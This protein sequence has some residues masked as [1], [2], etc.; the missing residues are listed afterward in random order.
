MRVHACLSVVGA[1]S[2]ASSAPSIPGTPPA[3]RAW[4]AVAKPEVFL[5]NVPREGY[6]LLPFELRRG[7]IGVEGQASMTAEVQS[8]DGTAWP[9]YLT[10]FEGEVP[11]NPGDGIGYPLWVSSRAFTP[12]ARYRLSTTIANPPGCLDADPVASSTVEFTVAE[13][14]LSE[15]RKGALGETTV[16]LDWMRSESSPQCC[17]ARSTEHCADPKSC[18]ACS[19]SSVRANVMLTRTPAPES[20]YLSL[21]VVARGPAGETLGSAW[22]SGAAPEYHVQVPLCLSEYCAEVAV[23]S[24]AMGDETVT[25]GPLCVPGSDPQIEPAADEALLVLD[26][27][28]VDGS[29][30]SRSAPPYCESYP[31]VRWFSNEVDGLVALGLDHEA[32]ES[33]ANHD[34]TGGTGGT[35][36][37]GSGGGAGKGGARAAQGT[38]GSTFSAS[39]AG[40]SSCAFTAAPRTNRGG[41]SVSSLLLGLLLLRRRPSRRPDKLSRVYHSRS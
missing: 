5:E 20:A 38:G 21:Y 10:S 39:G 17:V 31:D 11:D 15:R 34:G 16:A 26:N 7:V 8:D 37:L 24:P 22:F 4:A 30:F 12:G 6:L 40:P 2:L 9:G 13:E 14:A 41:L 28:C 27:P 1:T 33:Q 35:I 29:L 32:A 23:T 36:V 25:S 19:K 3:C 18:F